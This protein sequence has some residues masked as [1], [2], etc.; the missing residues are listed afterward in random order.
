[1]NEEESQYDDLRWLA[2]D[3]RAERARTVRRTA[4]WATAAAVLTTAFVATQQMSS[5]SSVENDEIV[6]RLAEIER[7]LDILI[8]RQPTTVNLDSIEQTLTS[9]AA[10]VARLDASGTSR[11]TI[12]G[13][14]NTLMIRLGDLTASRGAMVTTNTNWLQ[15]MADGPA[16]GQWRLYPMLTGDS[17]WIPDGNFFATLVRRSVTGVDTI[18]MDVFLAGNRTSGIEWPLELPAAQP[19]LAEVPKDPL[20]P[21]GDKYYVKLFYARSS[22]QRPG[23]IGRGFVDV[24]ICWSDTRPETCPDVLP[25]EFR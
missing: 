4:Y 2:R 25:A 17:L 12:A 7:R 11:E 15:I 13:S 16:Q 14:L 9:I 20:I 5:D 24:A 6:R 18:Y 22:S 1:M 10:L 8:G 21:N 19:T 23:F 3:A